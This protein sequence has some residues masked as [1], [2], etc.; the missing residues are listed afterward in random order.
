MSK[1]AD[2]EAATQLRRKLLITII[3]TRPFE[4]ITNLDL[5]Q[6]FGVSINTI[7]NDLCA[8]ERARRL[9]RWRLGKTSRVM[10][11]SRM[12][13]PDHIRRQRKE[14]ERNLC[15][16]G[17]YAPK[18]QQRAYTASQA[19][20]S[21][22]GHAAAALE[23]VIN[24]KGCRFPIGDPM[25]P[26]FRFCGKKPAKPWKPYCPACHAKTHAPTPPPKPRKEH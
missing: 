14:Y 24:K 5:A 7:S 15:R 4:L 16:G 8:L 1:T 12:I 22:N 26:G 11:T 18:R 20:V 3:E 21:L 2:K 9:I 23:Q 19:A 17:A 13:V 25:K 10:F 6:H